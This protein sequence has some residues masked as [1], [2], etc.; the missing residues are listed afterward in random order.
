MTRDKKSCGTVLAACLLSWI[1]LLYNIFSGNF[2]K[3]IKRFI[4]TKAVQ[5]LTLGDGGRN[6][7]VSQPICHPLRPGADRF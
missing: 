3:R 1:A 2:Y 4:I 6:T 7:I 5:I